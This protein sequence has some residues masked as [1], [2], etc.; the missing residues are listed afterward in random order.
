MLLSTQSG[1]QETGPPKSSALFL[2]LLCDAAVGHLLL[3]GCRLLPRRQCGD[4]GAVGIASKNSSGGKEGFQTPS[5][6]LQLL[7]SLPFVADVDAPVRYWV[8][9]Q[10]PG[11]A[12]KTLFYFA[13]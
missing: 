9:N 4:M 6:L 5:A 8:G 3:L 10:G 11:C 2:D 13:F 12:R 1:K 7:K